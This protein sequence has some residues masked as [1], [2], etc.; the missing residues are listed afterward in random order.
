MACISFSGPGYIGVMCCNSVGR[1][2]VGNKY[3]WVSFHE[4]TGPVFYR[5][6][7]QSLEYE[8]KGEDDPVW[9]A[10]GKWLDKYNSK[11]RKS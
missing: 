3:V 4:Y 1:L 10:F 7:S 11:K 5:N 6:M 8:P 2:H 9:T